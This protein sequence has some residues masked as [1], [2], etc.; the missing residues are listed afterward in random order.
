L[1][2]EFVVFVDR[3][4]VWMTQQQRDI[5][6]KTQVLAYAK[7]CGNV[8]KTCRHFGISRQCYYG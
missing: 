2:I 1:T 7:A 6:R 5:K 3:E 4:V 8:A